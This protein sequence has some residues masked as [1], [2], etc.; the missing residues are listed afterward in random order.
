MLTKS[1]LDLSTLRKNMG[2][3]NKSYDFGKSK[4][5]IYLQQVQSGFIHKPKL[6]KVRASGLNTLKKFNALETIC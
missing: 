2:K 1:T 5:P 6:R 4:T 3:V